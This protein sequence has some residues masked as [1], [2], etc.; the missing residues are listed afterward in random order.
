VKNKTTV[1]LTLVKRYSPSDCLFR[2]YIRNSNKL[3]DYSEEENENIDRMHTR[4]FVKRVLGNHREGGFD[5][6]NV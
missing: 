1:S 6:T 5:I 2:F 3:F 4:G